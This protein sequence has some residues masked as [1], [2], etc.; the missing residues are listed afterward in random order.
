[1]REAEDGFHN[2]SECLAQSFT[3]ENPQFQKIDLMPASSNAK[4]AGSSRPLRGLSFPII[5]GLTTTCPRRSSGY[6]HDFYS[7]TMFILGG[8]SIFQDA[9]GTLIFVKSRLRCHNCGGYVLHAKEELD[10]HLKVR[11]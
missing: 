10:A 9:Y 6:I 5:L 7:F 11:A 3:N 1:M 4:N 2:P 8:I